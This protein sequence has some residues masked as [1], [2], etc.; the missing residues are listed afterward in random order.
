MSSPACS[1]IQPTGSVG[2]GVNH[3]CRWAYS[4]AFSGMFSDGSDLT[5]VRLGDVE[6][7]QPRRRPTSPRARCSRRAGRG[8][9]RT[10]RRGSSPPRN[11]SARV[12]HRHEVLGA[13]V[14]AAAEPVGDRVAV[15][16][17][18]P[19]DRVATAADVQHERDVG[20][21]QQAPHGVEVGVR[22]RD[23]RRAGATGSAPSGS[24][25]RSPPA[26]RRR[27]APGSDIGSVATGISR[28]SSLQKSTIARVSAA[29]PP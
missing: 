15:V 22:R 14:L 3:S 1:I 10:R 8:S 12:V 7:L 27:C 13:D 2:N 17:E 23:A 6:A 19:R 18:R 26:A 24:R 4:D 11:T 28:S 5:N 16:V 21:G 25:G 29:D 20:L 9:A